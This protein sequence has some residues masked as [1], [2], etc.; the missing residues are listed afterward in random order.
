VRTQETAHK[1][2]AAASHNQAPVNVVER[3]A[4]RAATTIATTVASAKPPAIARNV[5]TR[6]VRFF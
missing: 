1:A 5:V 3:T 4:R 2:N 6:S